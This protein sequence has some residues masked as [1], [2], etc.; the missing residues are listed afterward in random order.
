MIETLHNVCNTKDKKRYYT[1]KKNWGINVGSNVL[2]QNII[3]I[4]D[5][6]DDDD[7]NIK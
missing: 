3:K 5:D 1:V 4:D 6:D 2:K 7:D